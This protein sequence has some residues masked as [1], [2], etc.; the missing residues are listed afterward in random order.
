MLARGMGARRAAQPLRSI[1]A[2]CAVLAVA[3]LLTACSDDE[4]AA[5]TTTATVA[6]PSGKTAARPDAGDTAAPPAPQARPEPLRVRARGGLPGRMAKSL[7]TKLPLVVLETDHAVRKSPKVR[8]RMGLID[9]ATNTVKGS[10]NGYDGFAGISIRGQSSSRFAKKSY[11]VELRDE[12]GKNRNETLLGMPAENDWA[13]Y[14]SHNDK[15]LMRNVVA[16]SAARRLGDWAARTRYVELVLNG[17]YQGAYILME[18]V[19]FDRGRVVAEDTGLGGRYLTEMTLGWQAR[20]KGKF[21]RTPVKKQAVV[22]DDPKREDLSTQEA[23]YIRRVVQ[24]FERDLYRGSRAAW[25]SRLHVAAAVD[26]ILLE[27][28][29]RNPDAFQASTYMVK[30]AGSKLKLGPVWDFDI[31]MGNSTRANASST[32]GWMTASRVWAERLLAD[33]RFKSELKRRW[34]TLRASGL[35]RSMFETTTASVRELGP[36]AQRNFRR[37]PVLNKRV[38]QEPVLRGSYKA[39]VRGLRSW[40]RGRVAWLDRTLGT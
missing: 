31:G 40:L 14:A 28:L 20:K 12:A 38:W 21:L 7:H 32:A 9:H 39:E 27:E 24:G 10:P 34:R 19:K 37:W 23:G 11:T 16:Y 29:F 6:S 2:A 13:L 22:Y 4:P 26:Y 30:G 1:A 8:A 15:S 25:R 5:T 17:R 18:T 33:P 3:A 36:A 35:R